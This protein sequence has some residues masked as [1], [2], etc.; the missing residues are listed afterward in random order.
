MNW[1][2]PWSAMAGKL[3]R[4]MKDIDVK[5]EDVG[6]RIELVEEDMRKLDDKLASI[7]ARIEKRNSR[8]F[9]DTLKYLRQEKLQLGEKAG[10]LRMEKKAFIDEKRDLRRERMNLLGLLDQQV[11][12]QSGEGTMDIVKIVKDT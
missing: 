5:I 11:G 2:L 1:V 9:Q 3:E 10:H 6:A 4:Q 8:G 12:L 7:E